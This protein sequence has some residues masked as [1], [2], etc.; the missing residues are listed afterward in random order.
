MCI[1]GFDRDRA[2]V[3]E[4]RAEAWR[5]SPA[6][7]RDEITMTRLG[8]DSG[9]FLLFCLLITEQDETEGVTAMISD[10]LELDAAD[11]WVRHDSEIVGPPL[12]FI[13]AWFFPIP[14]YRSFCPAGTLKMQT[15]VT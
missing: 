3:A 7:L 11:D 2:V 10:W 14:Q 1:L 9:I 12:S 6:F 5:A 8:M 13:L 4:E 15:Q